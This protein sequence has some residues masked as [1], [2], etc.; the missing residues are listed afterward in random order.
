M[1]FQK[2]RIVEMG[3]LKKKKLECNVENQEEAIIVA[4][5]WEFFN[6]NWDWLIKYKEY[7]EKFNTDM[8][9][10]K[11]DISLNNELENCSILVLTANSV[12]QNILTCKLHQEINANKKVAGGKLIETVVDG[13][14]YQFAT[15]QNIK[16]VHMHPYSTSSFT[17]GGSANAVRSVLERFRPK[18]VV[19]LGV[20]FGIEPVNQQLGDVLLSSGIIP[21][22]IFNKDKDGEIK[23]RTDDKFYTHEALHAWDVLLRN[24]MFSLE[25]ELCRKSL[26]NRELSF[27]WKYGTMLSGGSVLS[28]EKKKQALILA[29][30]NIGEEIVGGEMEGTGVYFECKKPDIPCIVIKGICDWGAKKNAWDEV[31]KRIEES[32]SI[33]SKEKLESITNDLIKDCVQAYAMDNA[34]EALFRLLRFDSAFLDNH[35]KHLK[36][37]MREN[38]KAQKILKYVNL[39]FDVQMKNIVRLVG[40]Y[41]LLFVFCVIWNFILKKWQY[42]ELFMRFIYVVEILGLLWITSKVFIEINTAIYPLKVHHSWID[43]AIDTLDIETGQVCLNLKVPHPIFRVYLSC[44]IAN[45]KVILGNAE[46]GDIK[47]K[48]KLSF[49]ILGSLDEK[50]ILQ[51]DYELANGEHYVH[52]IEKTQIKRIFSMSKTNQNVYHERIFLVNEQKCMLVGVRNVATEGKVLICDSGE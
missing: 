37:S 27:T 41:L 52:L 43:V 20:A 44:W 33:E 6:D 18:L 42:P 49:H 8:V 13:C 26:I 17:Q 21:Y 32:E 30:G 35:S 50:A 29:A 10:R 4:K 11:T 25:S 2:R 51:I 23:L 34:T 15:V 12:E 7:A 38:S 9:E 31:I 48:R 22:D 24:K 46:I 3:R 39:N 28:N 14:V 1:I 5:L 40:I 45:N 36:S 19:S 16:I 47:E